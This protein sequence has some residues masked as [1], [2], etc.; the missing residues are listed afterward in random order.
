MTTLIVTNEAV[1]VDSRYTWDATSSTQTKIH[2][3]GS[4]IYAAS[5][6]VGGGQVLVYRFI[7]ELL[8]V[9]KPWPTIDK[10]AVN[11]SYVLVAT[12]DVPHR[13]IHKGD[14]ICIDIDEGAVYHDEYFKV[15]EL[16][17]L[18]SVG[19]LTKYISGSGSSLYQ[20]FL[21]VNP[22]PLIAFELAVEHDPYSDFPYQRIDRQ[23]CVV[24]EGYRLTDQPYAFA[25]LATVAGFPMNR[26]Q[27]GNTPK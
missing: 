2:Q 12:E 3:Y 22:D 21:S 8:D 13:H 15:H 1:L 18:G 11:A 4:F 9:A 24:H 10:V 17:A 7:D 27:S 25:R 20:T 23:T 26:N 16:S 19:H 14:V 5:G 6:T